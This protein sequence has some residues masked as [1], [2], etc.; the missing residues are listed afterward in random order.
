[1]CE[2]QHPMDYNF[3]KHLLT[4]KGYETPILL[5][6]SE[7]ISFYNLLAGI[8]DIKFLTHIRKIM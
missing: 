4:R 1:M 7:N 6:H 3:Q 8:Y 5:F 2:R